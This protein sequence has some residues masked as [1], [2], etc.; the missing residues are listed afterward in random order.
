MKLPRWKFRVCLL[1]IAASFVAAG[2]SAQELKI[3]DLT[4]RQFEGGRPWIPGYAPVAGETLA[5]DFRVAGF[6][7][8]EGD[9]DDKIRVRFEA[10][11]VDSEGK[12]MAKP[13][14][15]ASAVDVTEEDKKKGWKP[16][17]SGEF[18]LPVLLR[19][20]GVTLR[21]TVEDQVAEKK[22]T[23]AEEFSTA[24]PDIPTSAG[25]AASDFRF[26]RTE[27]DTQPLSVRAY[28]QG[29][30]VW[31]RFEIVGFSTSEDNRVDVDYGLEV[32]D[33]TGKRLYQQEVAADERKQYFY[34]P[35]YVP[36]VVS[37]QLQNNTPLGEYTIRLT[38]RDRL[39]N[40]EAQSVHVFRI[41]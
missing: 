37:L 20:Q 27:E 28:R 36:G 39:T 26:L 17:F 16:K 33:S 12:P 30:M 41:E 2:L 40:R 14:S 13:V 4:L 19:R 5:F 7:S 22:A 35:A 23:V 8:V 11:L 6:A 31:G 34:P 21:V 24:G 18:Q 1:P 25:L 3:V 15:G 10:E 29:D 9:F 38:V 32:V